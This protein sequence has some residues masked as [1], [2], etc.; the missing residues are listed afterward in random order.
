MAD[1][2]E[3]GYTPLHFACRS[4]HHGAA[5]VLV[6]EGGASVNSRYRAWQ[7]HSLGTFSILPQFTSL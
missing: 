6:V 4:G 7:I 3:K 5:K 1:E 2:D